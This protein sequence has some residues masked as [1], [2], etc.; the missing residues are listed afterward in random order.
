[1]SSGPPPLNTAVY[2]WPSVCLLNSDMSDALQILTIV[3]DGFVFVKVALPAH[4]R[5]TK[6]QESA[7]QPAAAAAAAAWAP[8]RAHP[9]PQSCA[10]RRKGARTTKSRK[11]ALRQPRQR[12]HRPRQ[13]RRPLLNRAQTEGLSRTLCCE[14]VGTTTLRWKRTALL[15]LQQ[16][17]KS[18]AMAPA[19]M[20]ARRSVSAQDSRPTAGC[21][22]P[23]ELWK[24]AT[25]L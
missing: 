3:N 16:H 4:A 21:T 13:L 19:A 25:S 14:P 12:P 11:R 5:L 15:N 17:A 8:I 23:K 22:P 18:C 9:R 1:M 10:G 6:L 20:L 2:L 24:V 7:R